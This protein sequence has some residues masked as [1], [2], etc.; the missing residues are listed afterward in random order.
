M[1]ANLGQSVVGGVN[2][3]NFGAESQQKKDAVLILSRLCLKG[4]RT[5]K[6]RSANLPILDL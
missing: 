4:T 6:L 2:K 5:R 3:A 1:L